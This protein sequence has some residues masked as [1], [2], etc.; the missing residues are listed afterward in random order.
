MK[1]VEILRQLP[2]PKERRESD[3]LYS[4]AISKLGMLEKSGVRVDTESFVNHFEFPKEYV[5]K[6]TVYTKYNPYTITGRPSN[7][8]LGVNWGALNKSDGTRDVI[9][10]RFENGT[11]IQFDFESFHVRL[12][13]KLIG[14]EFP[15]EKTAHEHLAEWYGDVDRETAKGITFRYLY[16]GLDELGLTIPFFIKADEFIKK[17]Y[18]NY[19][20]NGKLIT[21]IMHREIPFERIGRDAGEQKVFNYFLQALETEINYYKMNELMEWFSDKKSKFILY[22]YDSFLIDTFPSER[23]NVLK[24][25]STI[26]EKGGF[27]VKAYEGKNYAN[28]EFLY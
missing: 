23:E 11:L 20:V 10:S 24:D 8:H 12:I 21:P 26:L 7:R 2:I 22:T 28:L 18:R 19:V 13:S 3:R 9:K 6:D 5:H 4:D 17:T 15:K 16:G 27:P 1:W 14:Y 25:I